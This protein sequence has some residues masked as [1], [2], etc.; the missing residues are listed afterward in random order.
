VVGLGTGSPLENSLST[1]H[2]YGV[3]VLSGSA[4]KGLTATF[5]ARHYE[6]WDRARPDGPFRRVFGWTEEAGLVTFQDA[7]PVPGKWHLHREVMTVHHQ[8]YYGGSDVPPADW[9]EP[10]PV[11]FLSVSGTFTV[12]LSAPPDD[13]GRDALRAV[14]ELLTRALAEEGL[15]AKTSSGFGRFEVQSPTTPSDTGSPAPAAPQVTATLPSWLSVVLAPNARWTL[16]DLRNRQSRIWQAASRL[17][18]EAEQ[19][20]LAPAQ[21]RQ[22]AQGI[23]QKFL[24]LQNIE[25]KEFRK[26]PWHATLQALSET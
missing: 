23:L 6:G 11:P 18:T 20:I 13:E 2:T 1:H 25:P 9:D 22:A 14:T 4:L 17:A 10:V 5:A 26:L 21:A 3:P 16:Q 12:I 19:G 7:L 24:P 15:G 8:A